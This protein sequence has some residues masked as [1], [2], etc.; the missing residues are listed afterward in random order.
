MLLIVQ[1]FFEK[2]FPP[3]TVTPQSRSA[4]YSATTLYPA[5]KH[6]GMT[7]KQ[8]TY[9]LLNERAHARVRGKRELLKYRF[10]PH[11]NFYT[12]FYFN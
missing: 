3:Y 2:C 1:G 10:L 12:I 8:I 9:Q 11:P 5:Q 4:G 7:N 6:C